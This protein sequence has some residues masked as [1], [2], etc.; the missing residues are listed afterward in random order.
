MLYSLLVLSLVLPEPWLGE[1]PGESFGAGVEHGLGRQ[2]SPAPTTTSQ[3]VATPPL[4]R[5]YAHI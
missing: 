2:K 1:L 5:T 4:T 3:E